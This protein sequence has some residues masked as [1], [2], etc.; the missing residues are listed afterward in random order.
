MKL[1]VL[2]L[3]AAASLALAACQTTPSATTASTPPPAAEPTG[4]P[5]AP[6]ADALDAAPPLTA[7]T[8]VPTG[9]AD[10][11]GPT[12]PH[13]T[14]QE[15]LRSGAYAAQFGLKLSELALTKKLSVDMKDFAG[16]VIADYTRSL[17]YLK[18]AAERA[19]AKLPTAVEAA[20][21]AELAALVKLNGPAFETAYVAQLKTSSQQLANTLAA[22]REQTPTQEADL[23]TWIG[24]TL[25]IAQNHLGMVQEVEQGKTK[26]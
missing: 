14:E 6:P 1:P 2:S 21:Q 18:P 23:Q 26:L 4:T 9:E 20:H 15:L 11:A 5:T 10:P 19:N 16:R 8:M 13:A 12:A 17:T 24:M 22:Y 7:A 25:P 3:L